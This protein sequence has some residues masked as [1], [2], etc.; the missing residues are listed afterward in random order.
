MNYNIYEEESSNS[1][2]LDKYRVILY[3]VLTKLKNNKSNE[4]MIFEEK[5]IF[6]LKIIKKGIKPLIMDFSNPPKYDLLSIIRLEI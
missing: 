4:Y 2:E 6:K 3:Q 1:S 5:D